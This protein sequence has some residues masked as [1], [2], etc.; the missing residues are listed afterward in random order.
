MVF[1]AVG[2]LGFHIDE[3]GAFLHG[4][5]VERSVPFARG[6][7]P[8][9]Y[10]LSPPVEDGGLELYDAL[11]ALLC[12][13]GVVDAVA[14]GREGIWEVELALADGNSFSFLNTTSFIS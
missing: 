1:V 7:V 4:L 3:I 5:A 11:I 8:R 10:F 9:V 13:V 2:S 14:I 12:L 6:V